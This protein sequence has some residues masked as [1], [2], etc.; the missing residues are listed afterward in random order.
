MDELNDV[1][2][3]EIQPGWEVYTGDEERLGTVDEVGDSTFTVSGMAA[4]AGVL[5]VRFDD[6]ESAG[7][8]RVTLM[9]GSD[10]IQPQVDAT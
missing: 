7:D 3:T 2:R 5:E 9:L 10:E 1:A 4:T 8:G 6:V